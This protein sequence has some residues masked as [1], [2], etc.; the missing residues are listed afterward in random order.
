MTVQTLKIATW[1]LDHPKP[2]SWKKTPAITDQIKTI[3]ADVW[4]LTETNNLAIDL[5][6][7]GYVKFSSIEYEDKGLQQNAYTTIWTKIQTPTQVI[8]TFDPEISVCI[9]LSL[10]DYNFLIYGTIITWHGDRGRDRKSRNWEEHYHSIAQHGNDW[11][12]IMKMNSNCKLMIAGDFNQARDGSGWYGTQKGIDS[13]TRQLNRNNLI[14]VTDKVK[15]EKRHNIDHIC[16][17]QELQPNCLA[18]CWENI[19]DN[20]VIMSD[21]NGVFV[22]MKIASKQ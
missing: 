14:C 11:E 8:N 16:I 4:I 5:L 17:S 3:N 12:K 6:S 15:P 20:D 7:L 9:K 1:N 2:K 22:E 18:N 10:K 19:S 21:H 13:L